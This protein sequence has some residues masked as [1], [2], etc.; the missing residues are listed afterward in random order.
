MVVIE[1]IDFNPF[2]AENNLPT[3]GRSAPGLSGEG[4]KISSAFVLYDNV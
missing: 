2:Q 4:P 1:K 3:T